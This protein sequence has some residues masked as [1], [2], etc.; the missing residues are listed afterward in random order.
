[1]AN[2]TCWALTDGMAGR[3]NQSLGLAEAIGLPTVVKR[4]HPRLP[5]RW[6]PAQ[7]WVAPFRA[8]APQSDRL[9][10]PWPDLLIG[11]GRQNRAFSIAVRA[12][13]DGRCRTV[14]IQDPMVPP[15]KFDLVVAPRHDNLAGVNVIETRGALHRVTAEKLAA[16]A[17]RFRAALADLPRP[18]VAVLIGGTNKAYRLTPARTVQLAGELKAMA[19]AA[20]GT[21][22][23]T[24]SR[25][26][27]ADNE[28]AL[29]Q[30][31][32]DSPA[33]IWDGLGDNPYLGWLG[34]A[35]AVV[36]TCDSVSM[37]SEACAA[38][39]PVHVVMLDGGNRKFRAFHA[40]LEADGVT[41][42][43][44]GKLESWTSEP[45]DDIAKVAVEIRRRLEL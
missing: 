10:P 11:T 40:G 5:W 14:Q 43:F 22:L 18:W 26:T 21:L 28:A 24:P 19:A 1:M 16:E 8:L 33:V 7:V 36:V 13:S 17:A 37:V 29:R 45:L 4:L 20:G 31:L 15:D 38:A 34:L 39:K 41:R 25:R 9:A 23:V 6:L 44:R 32:A 42:P 27:G 12:A 2:K 30:A 3:D 35:D